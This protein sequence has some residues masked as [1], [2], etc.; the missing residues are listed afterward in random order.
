MHKSAQFPVIYSF[1]ILKS[2][3]Y[4]AR[5]IASNEPSKVLTCPPPPNRA[6][7]RQ[8]ADAPHKVTKN[9][10]SVRITTRGTGSNQFQTKH[11]Y[12]MCLMERS[13]FRR[14]HRPTSSDESLR[15]FCA[16]FN[17][18]EKYSRRY[19]PMKSPE[20]WTLHKC[21]WV[22]MRE[23]RA[24]NTAY[25]HVSTFH[26]VAGDHAWLDYFYN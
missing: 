25:A 17:A 18:C 3:Q 12:N 23:K 10:G 15:Q 22:D 19:R 11:R 9:P 5:Q 24:R 1:L 14:F 2:V 7:L 20:L 26:L 16:W 6:R 8:G 21:Y 13:E 4:S